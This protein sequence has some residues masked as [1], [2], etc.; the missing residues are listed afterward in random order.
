MKR[1]T[2]ILF[3]LIAV[4]AGRLAFEWMLYRFIG[5]NSQIQ[6][7][8]K[9]QFMAVIA[10]ISIYIALW[11]LSVLAMIYTIIYRK[12]PAAKTVAKSL[13]G[14]SFS[15]WTML[16]A[17]RVIFE[18]LNTGSFVIRSDFPLWIYIIFGIYMISS[19]Y[20]WAELFPGYCINIGKGISLEAVTPTPE[21]TE[22][23]N[24][25]TETADSKGKT[26]GEK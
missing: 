4:I 26:A 24:I 6:L 11:P 16:Y 19:L 21:T 13:V 12:L 14:V 22:S 3:T 25:E 23:I 20:V 7:F 15:I 17:L 18:M 9:P 5:A 10:I 8:D 2:R 1:I